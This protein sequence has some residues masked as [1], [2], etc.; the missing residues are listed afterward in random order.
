MAKPSRLSENACLDARAVQH[1]VN[2]TVQHLVKLEVE[3]K[4]PKRIRL[5]SHRTGWALRDILSWMQSKVDTRPVGPMSPRIVIE[6][7]DRFIDKKEL[8][9]LVL[10][11]PHHLRKLE[12]AGRFPGHIR[13]GDNRVAWLEREVKDWQELRR[14]AENAPALITYQLRLCR[15]R[16]E[17]AEVKVKAGSP[18]TAKQ[19]A[20]AAVNAAETEWHILPF[21]PEAYRPHVETCFQDALFGPPITLNRDHG[22]SIRYLLLFADTA[23]GEGKIFQQ[24]WLS[25]ETL[26]N[27]PAKI[28]ADWVVALNRSIK[29]NSQRKTNGPDPT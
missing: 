20:L 16:F 13:I 24:P 29:P 21:E 10:Y 9:T 23:S 8:R 22:G 14:L 19:T 4:F 6:A 11:S 27:R 18:E 17:I 12:H 25:D 26:E 2:F 15:P 7:G 1:C 5:G 3:G 28:V